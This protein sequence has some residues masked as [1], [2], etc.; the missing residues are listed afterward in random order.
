[1]APQRQIQ[2]HGIAVLVLQRSSVV[3]N[4]ECLA[5]LYDR[6][7][8]YSESLAPLYD[9]MGANSEGL[10]PLYDRMRAYSECFAPGHETGF[11]FVGPILDRECR[12][13]LPWGKT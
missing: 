7:G 12:L 5:P 10:A 2:F 11:A 4:S 6:M 13:L 8:A 9:R 3:F 1:M